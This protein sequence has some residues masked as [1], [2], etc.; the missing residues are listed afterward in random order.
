MIKKSKAVF[1]DER[2]EIT[3]N[4]IPKD[5]ELKKYLVRAIKD[6]EQNVFCGVQVPKKLIP[7]VYVKKYE[8]DNLWKYNLPN[9]WRLLYSIMTPTK[10]EILSVVLEW[11]D[12]KSYERR[13][14]YLL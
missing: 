6:I 10:I 1:A 9:G 5:E 2:L 11:F 4:Q 12:H 8:I 14:K 3:F 7:K 13:F